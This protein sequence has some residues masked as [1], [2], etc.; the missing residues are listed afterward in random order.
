MAPNHSQMHERRRR[1]LEWLAHSHPT[2][3][4][5]SN[6]LLSME[7]EG[8]VEVSDDS[9]P[10]FPTRTH[11]MCR[12][13]MALLR[14]G[15]SSED[16]DPKMLASVNEHIR[17]LESVIVARYRYPYR[18]VVLSRPHGRD[19]VAQD[20][21][22][23]KS[24]FAP[25]RRLPNDVLLYIFQISFDVVNLDVKAS[26]WIFGYICHHWRALSRSSSSLWT[27]ILLESERSSYPGKHRLC[28]KLLSLSG[29]LPLRI[30]VRAGDNRDVILKDITLQSHRWFHMDLIIEGPMSTFQ[31]V[32]YHL[33][34][35][36]SLCVVSSNR[37]RATVWHLF[38]SAPLLRDLT[39][40]GCIVQWRGL[41]QSVSL[42]QLTKL[43]IDIFDYVYAD[44]DF[45]ACVKEATMLE[46]L[47][48]AISG[49]E[50]HIVQASAPSDLQLFPPFVHNSIWKL[51]FRDEIPSILDR[52]CMPNL[53][54]L[55]I[56]GQYVIPSGLEP[57]D[58]KV[59]LRFVLH[60]ECNVRKFC[61]FKPIPFSALKSL[62]ER[63]SS[64]LT[65][66]TITL[67]SATRADT[68]RE[69]T[70]E[71][72]KP[73]ILPNLQHLTLDTIEGMTI[74]EDDS[75]LK[76]AS[77]RFPGGFTTLT[78]TTRTLEWEVLSQ[79]ITTQMKHLREMRAV[80]IRVK[81]ILATEIDL[82]YFDTDEHFAEFVEERSM[83]I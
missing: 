47:Y 10:K 25:V 21:E 75:L 82:D 20:L 6:D 39:F 81:F 55:S 22:N 38:S 64:S 65:E 32:P 8:S 13:I 14:T 52:C 30:T 11:V 68:V 76:M 51:S 42:S 7:S 48:F 12:N 78:I 72:G 57:V 60:S 73:D 24:I 80:G 31:S 28:R 83:V 41:S 37:P 23:H 62:W 3:E 2:D 26:P 54:E 44:P 27:T 61:C 36:R 16:L 63:W 17:R 66:L 79:D 74:F 1:V 45:Y 70:F 53:K 34:L 33:P 56:S 49:R 50:D 71:E 67:T 15:Q 40:C 5:P 59:L 77:S 69:L 35:L 4:Q 19:F 29:N 58:L 46:D 18:Q 43:V 9:A